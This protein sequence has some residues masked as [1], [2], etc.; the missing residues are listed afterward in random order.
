[1]KHAFRFVV[2]LGLMIVA[3]SGVIAV[4]GRTEAAV[5]ITLGAIALAYLLIGMVA[6]T[7]GIR[8]GRKVRAD[9]AHENSPNS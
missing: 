4:T 5:L 6:Y 2:Y 8:Y 9:K 3:F 7:L 1:M